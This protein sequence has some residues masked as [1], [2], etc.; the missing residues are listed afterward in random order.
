MAAR[1]RDKLPVDKFEKLDAGVRDAVDCAVKEH[2]EAEE[3]RDAAASEQE[4]YSEI[5]A[6]FDNIVFDP[7]TKRGR[8]T[9][10]DKK[11]FSSLKTQSAAG[12]P[13]SDKQ[14]AAM[15][16]LVQ[17]YLP[18]LAEPEKIAALL[19]IQPTV[20]A[21]AQTTAPAGGDAAVPPTAGEAGAMLKMLSEVKEWAA[22]V[23]RGRYTYDDRKFYQSLA[24]QY[25]E[26]RSLSVKQL[27]ALKRLADKYK[28]K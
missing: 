5:F 27:A 2:T 15:K 10:D 4:N 3:K 26:G 1:Y 20:S 11:F 23:Q 19:D 24:K 22:P 16:K 8:I 14:V 21:A 13:L 9:Y 12:K 17:R 18:K 25:G 6:A 7:P 28:D